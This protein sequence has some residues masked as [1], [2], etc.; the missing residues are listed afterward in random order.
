MSITLIEIKHFQAFRSMD[1]GTRGVITQLKLRQTLDQLM[2]PINKDEFQRLW[3]R[4]VLAE[5][6]Q[7]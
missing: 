4:W 5:S 1:G 3:A 2:I 6:F 7:I